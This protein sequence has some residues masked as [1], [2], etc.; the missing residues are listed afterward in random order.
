MAAQE[1]SGKTTA[2]FRLDGYRG[3]EINALSLFIFRYRGRLGS[4]GAFRLGACSFSEIE[5]FPC[6]VLKTH[7]PDVPNLGDITKITERQIKKL[8]AIDL[9]VFGSPCQDLSTAGKRAGLSGERSGLFKTAIQIIKWA[10][11]NNGCRFAL[12]E[13][14]PGAFSSNK[15]ED[16]S[17][18]LRLLTGCKHHKPEKWRNS[19]I[20]FGKEGFT[21]WRTLDAQFFGVP[22]RR[23]RIF[24]LS[25]FGDWQ[26]RQPILFEPESL[27]RDIETCGEER[28]EITEAPISR[29][30]CTGSGIA[31]TMSS[32]WSK[33][34]GGPA[35]DEHY[36]LITI[37]IHDQATRF[38]GKRDSKQD[39]KGNGLGIGSESAP[40]NTLTSGDRHAVYC[41]TS[42]D[43][44]H[45][46]AVNKAP[47]LRS[48]GGNIRQAY[49]EPSIPIVRRLTPVECE[50]L[51]GF[52]DNWTRIK[53]RKN[54]LENCP[55]NPRYKAIGNSMAVPVMNWI[56]KRLKVAYDPGT[57]NNCVSLE[58]DKKSQ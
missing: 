9:V 41:G 54:E 11:K 1:F 40:M 2:V 52:P 32:K 7:Y 34:T 56:G 13:N 20:A 24:A 4:L 19:G 28:K 14:V 18:V 22:Q 58:L 30:D 5:P 6:E 16:F 27:Q 39:G 25:D 50:R 33:G 44:L 51:Q 10:R 42:N 35:G 17:E 29:I 43:A 8:G 15:G 48:G 53:W 38:S 49:I 12:W 23:R 31:G 45:D 36:N 26:G 55:D 47:T 21:E 3:L 37:P 57:K 46:F